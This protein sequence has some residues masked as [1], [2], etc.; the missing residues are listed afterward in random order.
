MTTFHEQVNQQNQNA[1]AATAQGALKAAQMQVSQQQQGQAS[2]VSALKSLHQ[3]MNNTSYGGAA[4]SFTLFRV[5]RAPLRQETT[6]EVI[7][8][9]KETQRMSYMPA[10]TPQAQGP[11]VTALGAN[12]PSRQTLAA[13]GPG[14]VFKSVPSPRGTPRE[15]VHQDLDTLMH[16]SHAHPPNILLPGGPQTTKNATHMTM[17]PTPNAHAHGLA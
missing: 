15:T 9:A 16:K 1:T 5:P 3:Q 17:G 6:E 2:N 4:N 11:Q 10:P 7:R 12:N 14:N 8:K 13:P